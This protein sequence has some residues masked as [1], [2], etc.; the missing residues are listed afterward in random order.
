MKFLGLFL[1]TFFSC[2]YSFAQS[3]LSIP[4]TE[5]FTTGL[6]NWR[7]NSPP[8]YVSP[9]DWKWYNNV[10]TN[11]D[12]GLRMKHPSDSNYVA[13][14]A[15]ELQAGK[16]YTVS[17]KTRMD[18]G[19]TDRLI[20]VGLNSVRSLVGVSNFFSIRI[21]TNAYAQPS[22]SEFNPTFTV[23]SSGNYYLIFNYTENGYAFTYL[24][25]IRVEE[26]QFPVVSITSPTDG[27][28][29][30]E[31]YA[32]STK[33]FISADASDTDGSI[34]KVEFFANNVKIGEDL[35]S[36]YQLLLKDVLPKDYV[37]TARATDNRGNVNTSLPINYRVNFRDGTFNNY[38]HWDF[39][40]TN[41]IGKG[42]DYW[43]TSGGEWVLRSPGFHGTDALED[44]SSYANNFAASPGVYLRTGKTYTLE[45]VGYSGGGDK[46]MNL[47]L[48]RKPLLNSNCVLIDTTRMRSSENFKVIH[49]KTFTVAQNGTYH[50]ILNYPTASSYIKLRFDN[51]R[52]I[53]DSLNIAP[54]AKITAPYTNLTIAENSSMTLKSSVIDVDGGVQK[55]EYYANETKVGE[56]AVAPEFQV[57]WSNI[58][59]G[60][61]NL[62]ARPIDFD[63]AQGVSLITK[64]KADTNRFTTSSFFGSVGDDDIRGIVYQKN[65]TIVM[66]ANVGNI[67][68]LNVPT[69][70]L[71]GATADSAGV[72]LRLA[73]DGKSIL[74]M[75]RLC[76][77]VA[78]LSKDNNDNLYVAA[79]KSGIFKLNPMA[80][81]VR[82]RKTF[83]K[84][85]HRIDAGPSGKNIAMV[86]IETDI[87][88]GT[89][90]E[91]FNYLHDENGNL[92]YQFP[93]VSQNGA[94]VAIDEV[95]QTVIRVGFKNFR[96]YDKKGGTQT[97]PVFVPVVRGNAYDGTPKYVGYDWSADT[98]STR[99]INRSENNMADARLNRCVIGKD[100]KLYL[101]GQIYGGNHCF[102]YD[103]FDIMK[104]AIVVGGDHF[105]TLSNTGTES[106]AFLGRYDPA[107]GL[108]DRGQAFTARLPNTKG[109]SVFVDQGAIDVDST[110]RIYLTG[111][112][113]WGLP[114]TTD[115]I[116][117]EYTGGAFALVLSPNMATREMCVR[118]SFGN[119]RAIAAENNQRW[120]FGGNSSD[121]QK[122][123]LVNSLQ[124]TNL[125]TTTNKWDAWFGVIDK[126]KCPNG[127]VLGNNYGGNPFKYETNKTIISSQTVGNNS[128][129]KQYNAK[130]FVEMKAGFDIRNVPVFEVLNGGCSN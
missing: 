79:W 29:I 69:K 77:R 58:A 98:N 67:S 19:S 50:L 124:T 104:P 121:A 85:V 110:G 54:L 10:G 42:M 75:T 32:D 116:P 8:N 114:L 130:N 68:A 119:G 95:S 120:I 55:V 57:T 30:S 81:S 99:W 105:F 65:G 47:L 2:F 23:S 48:N 106:H 64:I 1:L 118:L 74:S 71:N 40:A 25:E 27:G 115:Y 9:H 93:G 34:T 61:Y 92:M 128:N 78:D 70:L 126:A 80:D 102:R 22:F 46:T 73:S 7:V 11:S 31:N 113:A 83:S 108:E 52:I 16:T 60:D 14:P 103:P 26:T 97:L 24:D 109:N 6:N 94:D 111:T 91:T 76:T 35:I 117:G 20:S 100:G 88:D 33:V 18:Q 41:T 37:Y 43:T 86:A 127:Y 122:I 4:F 129:L 56:S 17:F 63:N 39:N 89:L 44:F 28:S 13:S 101:M 125:S 21:P 84:P 51:I 49:K 66:A 107:T 62:T 96:T 82:W 59:L 36:P 3:P 87:N 45:F 90:T 72:I 112:S 123:Y 53:G 38:A 12:G 15:I 5:S